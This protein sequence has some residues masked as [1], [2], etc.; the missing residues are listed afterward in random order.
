MKH[1]YVG[2][3]LNASGSLVAGIC[4]QILVETLAQGTARF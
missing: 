3:R 1:L 4:K 2:S